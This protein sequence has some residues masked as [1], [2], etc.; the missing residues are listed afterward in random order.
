M[1]W[2]WKSREKQLETVLANVAGIRGSLE[3]YAGKTLP[4]ME[5]MRLED[6]GQE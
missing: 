2:I 5:T 1:E 6:I 3:G 4:G